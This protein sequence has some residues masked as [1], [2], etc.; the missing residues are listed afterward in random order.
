MTGTDLFLVYFLFKTRQMTRK[1]ADNS[2]LCLL[3]SSKHAAA[4]T[5]SISTMAAR[6]KPLIVEPPPSLPPS[7]TPSPLP[8]P[9]FA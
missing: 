7:L 6:Q 3:A 8:A 1:L 4:R 2:A 9:I 5:W